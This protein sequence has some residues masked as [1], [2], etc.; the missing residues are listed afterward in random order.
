M[1]ETAHVFLSVAKRQLTMFDARREG[2]T[3][4]L[5]ADAFLRPWPARA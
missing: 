3:K 4:P 2:M 1:I 5:L